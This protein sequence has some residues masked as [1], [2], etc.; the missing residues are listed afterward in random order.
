MWYSRNVI[1]F[2]ADKWLIP[3]IKHIEHIDQDDVLIM[4]QI[5]GPSQKIY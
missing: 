3:S 4:Y 2:V 5:S 1:D